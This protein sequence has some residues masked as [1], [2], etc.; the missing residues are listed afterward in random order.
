MHPIVTARRDAI[1][2]LC[3][4]FH[5]RRLEVFGSAARGEDFDPQRSDADFLVEFESD[6]PP[7]IGLL[8]DLE[9]A[10]A[11]T[12]GRSVD[13]AERKAIEE[14][15]NYLRRRRIMEEA[16]PVYVAG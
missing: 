16:E 9:V 1:A 8:L 13:L 6:T 2:E 3:R 12:L 14:G 5:V 11:D 10:L 7:T 15:G 4:R